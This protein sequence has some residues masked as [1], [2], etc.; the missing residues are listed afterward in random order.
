[1][2]TT[3]PPCY[4]PPHTR[5]NNILRYQIKKAFDNGE[6]DSGKLQ[7]QIIDLAQEEYKSLKIDN[8]EEKTQLILPY[9]KNYGKNECTIDELINRTI[10]T[11]EIDEENMIFTFKN[12]VT[13]N[14]PLKK[15]KNFGTMPLP[16]CP[17]FAPAICI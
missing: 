8:F 7:S 15:P 4:F 16:S 12:E 17:S 2:I 11:V 5:R 13:I 1:V 6:Y 10:D 3:K 9:I 14:L